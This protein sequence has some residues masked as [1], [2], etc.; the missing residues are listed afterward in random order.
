MSLSEA[1]GREDFGSSRASSICGYCPHP[2]AVV[3]FET[4]NKKDGAKPS[5]L[6]LIGQRDSQPALD[7]FAESTVRL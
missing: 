5:L 7:I 1:K 2:G 6:D 3:Q 4:K